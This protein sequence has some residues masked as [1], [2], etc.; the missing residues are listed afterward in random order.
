M[1]KSTSSRTTINRQ[2]KRIAFNRTLAQ[3]HT[4]MGPHQRRFSRIVHT[5]GLEHI[6][7][8]I[9]YTIARPLPLICGSMSLIIVVIA[10]YLPAKQYGYTLSGFE[11]IVA[12][13][14]GWSIG[15]IVDYTRLLIRGKRSHR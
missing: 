14:I 11:P 12:F 5:R 13:A 15:M 2:K 6:S 3:A 4:R 1:K 10:I 8:G 7:D 9:G